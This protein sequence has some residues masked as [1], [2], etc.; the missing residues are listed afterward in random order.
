VWDKTILAGGKEKEIFCGE[1]SSSYI[2]I[3]DEVEY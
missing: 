1:Y 2:K 3:I